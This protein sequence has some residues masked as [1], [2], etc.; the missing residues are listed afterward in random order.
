MTCASFVMSSLIDTDDVT[1]F[2][3]CI[4]LL[5]GLWRHHLSILMTSLLVFPLYMLW[6]RIIFWRL[7]GSAPSWKRSSGIVVYGHD[8]IL[9][10]GCYTVLSSYW[11]VIVIYCHYRPP[12]SVSNHVAHW[13]SISAWRSTLFYICCIYLVHIVNTS[14]KGCV[15][16]SCLW[17]LF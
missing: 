12:F 7:V 11:M 14:Y 5:H 10:L 3:V 6:Y 16:F 2:T 1:P 15:H 9:S 13:C 17:K 4:Y 8:I